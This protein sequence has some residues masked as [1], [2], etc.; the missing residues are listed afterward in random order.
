MKNVTVTLPE[1]LERWLRIRAAEDGLTVSGW[2][3]SL[4]ERTRDREQHFRTVISSYFPGRSGRVD[5]PE[6]KDP[7]DPNSP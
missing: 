6:G 7:R 4:I 1:N 3:R 2:I 5:W